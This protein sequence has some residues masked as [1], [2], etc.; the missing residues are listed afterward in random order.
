MPSDT[1]IATLQGLAAVFIIFSRKHSV[2]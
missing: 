1:I 2:M